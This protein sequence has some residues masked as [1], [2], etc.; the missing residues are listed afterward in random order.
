MGN[1]YRRSN[2]D[3]GAS[4]SVTGSVGTPGKHTLTEALYANAAPVQRKAT[5][6]ATD[7]HVHEAAQRG[8]AGGGTALPHLDVIQRAF[9]PHDVSNTQAHTGDA[10]ARAST[11]IGAQAYATG[12]HVA[13][14]SVP[15]L[16][17]TAHEAAHVVQQRT[18]VHLKSGVGETGDAYERNADEVADRVVRGESAVDLLPGGGSSPGSAAQRTVSGAIQRKDDKHEPPGSTVVTGPRGPKGDAGPQGPKGD[19]GP[20]GSKGDAGPQGPRGEPGKDIY[21]DLKTELI[22]ET[23]CRMLLGYTDFASACQTVGASIKA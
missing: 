7:D 11:E 10:A 1:D 15:D 17:T 6:A 14:A 9:G 20:Q 2:R 5:G 22:A 12:N 3:P 16:R 4:T 18:G 19:A 21:N 13:F 8:V 23:T